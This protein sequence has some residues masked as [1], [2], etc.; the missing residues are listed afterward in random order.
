MWCTFQELVPVDAEQ[1]GIL[2][3]FHSRRMPIVRDHILAADERPRKKDLLVDLGF[4]YLF[5]FP[6][7]M[8]LV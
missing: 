8:R 5:Q 7:V 6:F 3:C 1:V 4:D 2:K